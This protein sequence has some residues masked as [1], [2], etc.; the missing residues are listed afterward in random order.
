MGEIGQGTSKN[1]QSWCIINSHETLSDSDNSEGVC[2]MG[3]E[4][5]GTI[6]SL[7]FCLSTRGAFCQAVKLIEGGERV[8]L[9]T[10][11]R[12]LDL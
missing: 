2:G 10:E 6:H 11:V 5:E 12:D 3:C 7:A 8:D 9:A 4:E 1:H